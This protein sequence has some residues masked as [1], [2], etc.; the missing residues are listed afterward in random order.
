M[1]LYQNNSSKCTKRYTFQT[2]LITYRRRKN[3]DV[4]KGC[5]VCALEDKLYM[6]PILKSI[7]GLLSFP[8]NNLGDNHDVEQ[9]T[10]LLIKL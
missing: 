10:R 2:F 1:F 6:D 9:Q 8:V 5:F 3:L 7:Y 4:Y